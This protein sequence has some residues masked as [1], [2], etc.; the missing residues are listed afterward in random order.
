MG[1]PR[2]NRSGG[3]RARAGRRLG[4]T[5]LAALG[6]GLIVWAVAGGPA[7]A[8]TAPAGAEEPRLRPSDLG[9][10]PRTAS[11][12]ALRPDTNALMRRAQEAIAKAPTLRGEAL[13]ASPRSG[14]V[15]YAVRDV[16][17]GKLLEARD[18]HALFIPASLTKT[19]TALYAL[20]VLGD[21][22]RYRTSV[23]GLGPV[24]DGRL[25]GDLTLVGSGDPTL[26]TGDLV[27]LV[28]ALKALG[29][30][31][32]SGQ[33]LYDAAA[34]PTEPQIEPGQPVHAAYNPSIS[35][36]NLN[37]N[38][39]LMRWERL[40]DGEYDLNLFAHAQRWSAPAANVLG[41]LLAPDETGIFR[42]RRDGDGDES[43]EVSSK[44]LGRKGSRW[45]PIQGPGRY[46]A[47][48]FQTVAAEL[49]VTLPAPKTGGV[50]PGAK[51]LAAVESEPL[52]EIVRDMLKFS[53]NLTAE[54][55]G[56]A[57][58]KSRGGGDLSLS[59]SA[60]QMSLW[61]AQTFQTR[62][63]AMKFVNHSGLT[64]AS[65][66]SPAAMTE[67]L[68]QARQG[69]PR[70]AKL[71]PK[72]RVKGVTGGDVRAKTGTMYYARGLSGFL[73]C[74]NGVEVAFTFMHSDDAKRSELDETMDPESTYVPAA[75]RNWLGRARRI[76]RGLLGR[77]SDRYCG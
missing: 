27:D 9:P 15:G 5:A 53:T 2:K 73:V 64:S 49:G 6:S 33:F 68:I 18:E 26:D 11:A 30:T 57:A 70:F 50:A 7:W 65:R 14:A 21:G 67:L 61:T 74:D 55:V 59:S 41:G 29:I 39:V 37:F 43:W 38:R 3:W 76:E 1:D 63:G 4:A 31:E 71:M 56:L 52:R 46:A 60:A 28:K 66:A 62:A 19:P 58:S 47:V 75:A 44:V 22:Q 24:V 17:S 42:H 23:Y 40:K 45:L 54:A 35:G 32:V 77:W 72:H 8:D 34:L 51:E 69:D 13:P 10:A 12:P 36:L 25:R 48:A 20:T 16:A